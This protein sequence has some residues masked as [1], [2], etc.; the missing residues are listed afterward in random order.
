MS[1]Q[2]PIDPVLFAD[3]AC[4]GVG[5]DAFFPVTR[6]LSERLPAVR[7][8]E[9]C[10]VLGLCAAYA[11]PLVAAGAI[12]GCVIASV[13]VPRSLN[14]ARY[15]DERAAAVEELAVIAAGDLALVSVA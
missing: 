4:N 10:P 14:L 13:Y 7:L 9:E 5:A 8:C 1:T 3:R 2:T 11:G 6:K 12:R 15:G